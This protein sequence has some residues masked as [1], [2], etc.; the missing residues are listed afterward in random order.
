MNKG[1]AIL[2]ASGVLGVTLLS[3]NCGGKGEMKGCMDGEKGGF[4][5]G[6]MFYDVNL[7]EAQKDQL[8]KLS[9]EQREKMY[10]HKK[11]C[12]AKMGMDEYIKNGKFDKETFVKEHSKKAQDMATLR[13][14]NFEKMY[15]ILT[16]EQK[17]ELLSKMKE[18]KRGKGMCGKN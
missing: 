2:I 16:E 11:G 17:K 5:K 12:K 8:F 6:G 1:I 9:Q 18:G 10:E 15:N 13:A 14:E 3:A 7:S 4:D